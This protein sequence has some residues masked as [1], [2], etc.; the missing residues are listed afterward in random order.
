MSFRFCERVAIFGGAS[1]S[2]LT[3][4]VKAGFLGAPRRVGGSRFCGVAEE[5]PGCGMVTRFV[6]STVTVPRFGL[7][8][9]GWVLPSVSLTG[10]VTPTEGDVLSRPTSGAVGALPAIGVVSAVGVLSVFGVV[11]AVGVSAVGVVSV[12]GVVSAV[13]VVSAIRV[14]RTVS[15]VS[16]IGPM[17]GVIPPGEAV[18]VGGLPAWPLRGGVT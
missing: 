10:A 16:S 15:V 8:T 17:V 4:L 5:L 18:G 7:V 6:S 14:V 1:M 12:F 2:C 11:S 9:V 13:G 3:S